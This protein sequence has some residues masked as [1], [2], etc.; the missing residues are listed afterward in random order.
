MKDQSIAVGVFA[1]GTEWGTI[2]KVD[3]PNSTAPGLERDP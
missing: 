2:S 3:V 1:G